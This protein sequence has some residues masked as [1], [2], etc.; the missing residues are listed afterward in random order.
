MIAIIPLITD[1]I[2]QLNSPYP[3]I[4]IGPKRIT[5]IPPPIIIKSHIA[6]KKP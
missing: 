1:P 4:E 2:N 6:N 3:L 5:I